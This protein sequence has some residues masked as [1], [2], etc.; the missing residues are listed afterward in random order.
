MTV[1]AHIMRRYD[2]AAEIAPITEISLY[3]LVLC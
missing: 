1:P 3:R 2:I